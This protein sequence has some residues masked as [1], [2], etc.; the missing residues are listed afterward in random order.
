MKT[1]KLFIYI[2]Y[3]LSFCSCNGQQDKKN[4]LKN[5]STINNNMIEKILKKQLEEGNLPSEYSVD[6]YDNYDF[7]ATI[8]VIK[9]VLSS[10][11]FKYIDKSEFDNRIK[12]IFGRIIDR[13]SNSEY[14]YSDFY[15]KCDRKITYGPVSAD[16]RG[17]FILKNEKFITEFYTLPQILNYESK[18]PHLKN[19]EDEDHSIYDNI[20]NIK[21]EI[22]SWKDIPNLQQTRFQNTQT[23]IHRNKYLFNDSKADFVWLR[24]NGKELQEFGAYDYGARFYMPDIGRWGVVDP[25]A[26]MDRRWSPY[27]YAYDNPLRFIDPDGM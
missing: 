22:S 17:I 11:G 5:D 18:Y 2:S 16:V 23:I 1:A 26:E 4:D 13:T 21:V 8:P 20:E 15:D 14:L 7:E 24:F 6:A 19:L 10:S 9:E 25:L 12:L 27:R 3:F